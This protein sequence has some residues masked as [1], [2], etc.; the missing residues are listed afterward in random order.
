[1]P[2]GTAISA[3]CGKSL[4]TSTLPGNGVSASSVSSVSSALVIWL[5]FTVTGAVAGAFQ[6]RHGALSHTLAQV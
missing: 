3:E 2:P 5:P 6:Y 4:R 1:V